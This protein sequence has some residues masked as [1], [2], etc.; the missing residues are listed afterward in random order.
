MGIPR[1]EWVVNCVYFEA[2]LVDNF[3]NLYKEW[4]LSNGSREE[5]LVT[6]NLESTVRGWLN[7]A[8][9]VWLYRFPNR[10]NNEETEDDADYF[11][12]EDDNWVIPRHLFEPIEYVETGWS[13]TKEFWE[14][15]CEVADKV[16]GR[17]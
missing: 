6:Y 16:N 13:P 8:S 12:K 9:S 15:A 4:L 5:D 3:E 10:Y 1:S 7:S 2:K 11:E 17:G 14:A